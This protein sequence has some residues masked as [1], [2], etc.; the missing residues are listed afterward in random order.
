MTADA[1]HLTPEAVAD[2]A[3]RW[4]RANGYTVTHRGQGPGG[5][6]EITAE[7]GPGAGWRIR[8]EGGAGFAEGF[9]A[10]AAIA[11]ARE[12]IRIGLAL[13]RTPATEEAAARVRHAMEVL[14]ITVLWA[15]AGGSISFERGEP[16]AAEGLRPEELNAANDD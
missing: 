2:A 3:C 5:G 16:H 14:G 4:L 7:G 9:Y 10:A 12:P 11:E 6:I 1:A 8:A 15:D 13:A